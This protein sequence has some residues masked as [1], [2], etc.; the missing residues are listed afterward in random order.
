MYCNY[1]AAAD[2]KRNVQPSSSGTVGCSADGDQA[3]TARRREQEQ[4][5]ASHACSVLFS[6]RNSLR[7]TCTG[8]QHANHPCTSTEHDLAASQVTQMQTPRLQPRSDILIPLELASIIHRGLSGT[9]HSSCIHLQRSPAVFR[10]FG[11]LSGTWSHHMD[12]E[13]GTRDARRRRS[14]LRFTG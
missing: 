2:G 7:C 6:Q 4:G 8:P 9:L 5:R 13:H 3:I 11:R 14:R 1:L 10:S 12:M